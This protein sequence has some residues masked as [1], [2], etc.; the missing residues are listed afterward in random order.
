MNNEVRIIVAGGRDFD[1]WDLARKS[2][3]KIL[4]ELIDKHEGLKKEDVIFVSGCCRG[5]D[6]IGERY[7]REYGY[8]QKFFA[9]KW[10][11]YGRQA[12]YLRNKEMAEYART[13]SR[14]GVLIAFWDGSSMGTFHMVD[15][16]ERYRLDVH[17]VR[18][19]K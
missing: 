16:A 6:K 3:H 5:A 15:L 11:E 7:A 18:Y 13:N 8:N 2:I 14:Q 12:G 1:D 17:I 9:A 19:K 4:F 10:D